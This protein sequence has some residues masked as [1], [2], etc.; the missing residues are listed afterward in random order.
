MKLLYAHVAVAGAG[1]PFVVFG[2]DIVVVDVVVVV[3]VD[4]DMS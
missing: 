2:H 4:D 1:A 3:V